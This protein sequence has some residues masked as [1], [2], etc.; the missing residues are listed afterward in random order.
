MYRT[1][2]CPHAPQ[3][4]INIPSSSQ[5]VQNYSSEILNQAIHYAFF[6]IIGKEISVPSF[7]AN[8][9]ISEGNARAGTLFPDTQGF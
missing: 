2:E 8:T 1:A 4:P 9:I 6:L 5:A 7:P 3:I